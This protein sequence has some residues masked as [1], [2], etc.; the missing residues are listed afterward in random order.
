M[1]NTQITSCMCT[2]D[3]YHRKLATSVWLV[4][5]RLNGNARPQ[6]EFWSRVRLHSKPGPQVLQIWPEE[7]GA[8]TIEWPIPWPVDS[9]FH[10][11]IL[12]VSGK[13]LLTRSFRIAKGKTKLVISG[14]DDRAFFT[15]HWQDLAPFEPGTTE[16]DPK[17][18]TLL[19]ETDCNL[20]EQAYIMSTF[21]RLV[22]KV[23]TQS[24]KRTLLDWSE[25][26][27]RKEALDLN[28]V[29][30]EARLKRRLNHFLK[31]ATVINMSMLQSLYKDRSLLQEPDMGDALQIFLSKIPFKDSGM[32]AV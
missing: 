3:P 22:P 23:F 13:R 4:P 29:V 24:E 16:I 18:C 31:H 19:Y 15:M 11:H 8:V 1:I 5:S 30:N 28:L 12:G 27:L 32:C 17:S 25:S 10:M 2:L 6:Q 9:A 20:M 14:P 21:N 26:R 7:I